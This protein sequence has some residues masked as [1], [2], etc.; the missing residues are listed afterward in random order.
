[1]TDL[2]SIKAALQSAARQLLDGLL[3]ELGSL[4]PQQ[5]TRLLRLHTPLGPDVL[6][7]EKAHITEHIGPQQAS[8]ATGYQI[9]LLALST[10]ADLAPLDLIGQPVLLEL[11][12]A[13]SSTDLRP[14]H[15]HV[16][17]MELLGSDGGYARYRLTIQPWT[18][19]LSH[20]HDAYVFQNMSVVEITE[21]IFADYAAQG[22]LQPQW[23]WELADRSVYAQR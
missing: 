3:A 4:G 12:T 9:E 16:T 1:M 21:A 2:S 17:A 19:F 10:R 15:G 6:L 23:R 13:L 8:Q 14:F 7:A 18:H 5:H 20:R 11:L 22:A